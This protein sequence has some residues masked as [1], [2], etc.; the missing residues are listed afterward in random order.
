MMHPQTFNLAHE[1]QARLAGAPTA[2]A[3]RA[4]VA[5]VGLVARSRSPETS[6]RSDTS[7]AVVPEL[8]DYPYAAR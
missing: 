5:P 2:R 4:L 1:H 8:R 3:G 6:G 7:S